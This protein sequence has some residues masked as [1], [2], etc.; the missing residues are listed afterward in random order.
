MLFKLSKKLVFG[1]LFTILLCSGYLAVASYMTSPEGLNYPNPGHYPGQIGPGTFNTSGYS[2][3]NWTFPGNLNVGGNICLD[4]CR[5]TWPSGGVSSCSDCNSDFVNEGQEGSISS[6]MIV[7]NTID[8]ADVA[9]N[10]LTASSLAANSVGSSELVSSYESGSAYDSRFVNEG[11]KNSISSAMIKNNAITS[12]DID[13]SSVQERVSDSCSSGSSIRVIKAGGTVICEPDNTGIS[14]CSNCDRRF[15]N[16]YGDWMRGY[17][18]ADYVKGRSKLCIGSDCRTS[19]PS[20]GVSSCSDCNSDFVNEGGD[21]MSGNLDV[22]GVTTAE[23]GLDVYKS[24]TV[25]ENSYVWGDLDVS[26]KITSSGGVDPPY[27][28]FEMET[29][30]SIAERVAKEIPKEKQ[31]QAIQFWNEE[32]NQFEVYLPTKGEFRD[33]QGNILVE[34]EK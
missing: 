31:N 22:S 27:V 14:S 16:E 5:S 2:N 30:K 34:I 23:G 15:V 19:W 32:T 18:N 21:T 26:G 17:L 12:S 11:Q 4:Y 9:D 1:I 25:R 10:S 7:D 3:P 13:S 6:A 20:G 24:A 33:L 29:R 8:D 28:S